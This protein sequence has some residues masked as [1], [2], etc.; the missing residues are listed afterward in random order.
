MKKFLSYILILI[1]LVGGFGVASVKQA[2]ADAC[3]LTGWTYASC[4]GCSTSNPSCAPNSGSSGMYN[5]IYTGT[6]STPAGSQEKCTAPELSSTTCDSDGGQWYSSPNNPPSTQE[7]VSA[8]T[9]TPT[10]GTPAPTVG[11][12]CT[13]GNNTPP[14]CNATVNVPGSTCLMSWNVV[15]GAI[16]D[17]LDLRATKCANPWGGQLTESALSGSCMVQN[18]SPASCQQNNGKYY[19]PGQ[20]T[21]STAPTDNTYHLLSPLPCKTG[22]T[23]CTNG[24][25]TTFDPTQAN[26]LGGYLNL[27]IKIFIGL[28][29]V[30][31]VIMIVM[32]GIEYMTSEL[33][34]SKE[35]GKERITNA[36]FGLLLA[37]AA[38]TLL[39]TINPNILNTD[40]SSLKTAN[41]EIDL[42]SDVPQVPVNGKYSSGGVQG[43][44][45]NDQTAGPIA[46]LPQGVSVYNAQCTTIGQT[47]CTS[48]RGL[49]LSYINTILSSCSSCAPLS[50]QGGTEYWLHGGHSGSTSHG[51]G[52]P[53]VDI[54]VNQNLTNWI[55]TGDPNTQASA[56]AY[57]TR[58]EQA[59]ISF[60]WENNHW[61]A[62]P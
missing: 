35:A 21:L 51:V 45:W 19:P 24:Q 1:A 56:P 16:V 15:N 32:G 23:N 12:M 60:L 27:I 46:I 50:I 39:Y 8:I 31:A 42:E 13:G 40:L 17:P 48:T 59:G 55:M 37:L 20:G 44:P 14:G 26:N 34:S 30:L 43:G 11:G 7:G 4:H 33:V 57:F 54:G 58:H 2:R 6:T 52:S 10:G 53:T 62:G 41:I 9:P 3:V 47:G 36:I 18:W 49:S 25:L 29:G 28:C 61:H 22:D 38:W 5:S